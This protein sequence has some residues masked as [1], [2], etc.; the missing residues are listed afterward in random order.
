MK[1]KTMKTV[2]RYLLVLP[3]LFLVSSCSDEDYL[4]VIPDNST[5]LVAIDAQKLFDGNVDGVLGKAL[6]TDGIDKCGIDFLSKIY[7]FETFDG[8]IGVAAKVSDSGDLEDF[9]NSLSKKG[10]CK[11]PVQYEDFKFTVIKDTWVA[12]FSSDALV[13]MGPSLPAVQAET[14]RQIVKLLNQDEEHGIKNSPMFEKMESIEGAVAVVAQASAL[15]EKLAA[16]F[17]LGAPKDADLSQI[18]IAADLRKNGEG[19]ILID[20]E[21]FSFNKSIDEK[22]KKLKSFL[23]ANEDVVMT[24]SIIILP[25]HLR[26]T[27]FSISEKV[28]LTQPLNKCYNSINTHI[29]SIINNVDEKDIM[30]VEHELFEIQRCMTDLYNQITEIIAYKEGLARDQILSNKINFSGRAVISVKHDNDPTSVSLPKII[31]TEI[32]MPKILTY[33]VEHMKLSYTDATEYYY[34]N[35]F[36]YDNKIIDDAIDEI[37]LTKPIVLLNRN[38]SLHLLSIQAFYVSEVTNDYTIKLAK[39]VLQSFNA[40]FDLI[41]LCRK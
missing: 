34:M 8:N 14:K 23:L 26:P 19:C 21:T 22:L 40:D 3:L 33:I 18:M 24:D 28:M 6:N 13:V 11:G 37:L 36:D 17:T 30:A 31:F 7:L 27:Q 4:N 2:V 35:R 10:I 29:H 25:L 16:P 15:P 39:P 5:A 12:G 32:Y 20:G 9:L 41:N 1:M 38:P